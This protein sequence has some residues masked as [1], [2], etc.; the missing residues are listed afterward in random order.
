MVEVRRVSFRGHVFNLTSSEGW[1]DAEGII[2]SNCD[3]QH[4][5]VTSWAEAERQGLVTDP[6]VAFD[7]GGVRGLSKA[8]TQAVRDGADLQAVVNAKRGGGRR[9]AGMTNAVTAEI[10]GRTVKATTEGTTRRGEWR[11]K[12]PDL[13]IRLRPQ[14]VYEHARDRDDAVRLLRL[15]GYLK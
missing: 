8:D 15:Y 9:P 11:R 10:F 4:F 12:H 3:C 2:V 14:S 1:Y 6:M 7:R 13:P 5:P